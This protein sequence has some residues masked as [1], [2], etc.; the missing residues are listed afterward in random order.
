MR[1][2]LAALSLFLLAPVAASACSCGGLAGVQTC[3]LFQEADAVFAGRVTASSIETSGQPRWSHY[4]VRF[5]VIEGFSGVTGRTIDIRT[6]LGRGDCGY[7]FETG[8]SYFVYA[9]RSK[10]G[11]LRTS[12]CTATKSLATA[13]AD[14]AF[15]RQVIH[16]G[17]RTRLYGRVIRLVRPD[18][19]TYTREVDLGGVTVTI[20]GPADQRF[21]AVTDAK[22]FFSVAGSR[23]GEYAVRAATPE[24]LPEITPQ[25]VTIPAGRCNG[26]MLKSSNLASLSGRVVDP[27]GRPV[28][29]VRLRL[30]TERDGLDREEARTAGDGRYHFEEIPAGSYVLAANPHA[31][32]DNGCEE[33]SD[34]WTFFPQA[35]SAK[36]A[37]RIVLRPQE[38]R[39]LS[40]FEL[41]VSS[42]P[43]P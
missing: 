23:E 29:A 36:E 41:P 34:P 24:G 35:A 22:G 40:D 12:I 30:L 21:T 14:L 15:A 7:R 10:D 19:G 18:L 38:M 28:S 1:S 31:M 25:Q 8:K 37:E 9:S 26:V 39:E 2:L 4:V 42:P 27:A 43:T 3:F 13:Q 20:E 11:V 16:G 33:S 32:A 17:N 5:A 6:G